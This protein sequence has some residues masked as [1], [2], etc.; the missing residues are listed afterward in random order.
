MYPRRAKLIRS[1]GG[2]PDKPDFGPPD[3][4]LVPFIAPETF[5]S[6]LLE[7]LD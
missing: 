2:L 5:A 4:E 6:N 3:P 1:L 7:T